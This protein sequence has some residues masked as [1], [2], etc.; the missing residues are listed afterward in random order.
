M[1]SSCVSSGYDGA[2]AGVG[3]RVLDALG[4][5][6]ANGPT[7]NVFLP[8]WRLAL[9][10]TYPLLSV[11]DSAQLCDPPSSDAANSWADHVVLMGNFY[12]GGCSYE[13][14][15]RVAQQR[16]AAGLLFQADLHNSFEWDGS[17]HTGLPPSAFVYS[18]VYDCLFSNATGSA[19][20]DILGVDA[21]PL[22][23]GWY[24]TLNIILA[25]IILP[26]ILSNV[27]LGLWQLHRFHIFSMDSSTKAVVGLE[28]VSQAIFFAKILNG[29][30][31]DHGWPIL[32]PH[33]AS[34]LTISV[35]QDIH[36]IAL[37]LVSKQLRRTVEQINKFR[38][39]SADE[40]GSHNPC[41]AFCNEHGNTLL[42]VVVGIFILIELAIAIL[43]ANFG[44][45]E[46]TVD[47]VRAA[48]PAR[49]NARARAHV[50]AL[51]IARAGSL[52]RLGSC[53]NCTRLQ[54]TRGC[55]F[56]VRG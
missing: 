49:Q 23:G 15:A 40:L 27:V 20:V 19:S 1:A 21:S 45:P 14:R 16:G 30:G 44:A 12:F 2:T 42:D 52:A 28:M 31:Y 17:D 22:E 51:G 35:Y 38:T 39:V 32:L 25:V 29:T 55:M 18:K 48:A 34:R 8:P 3:I 10:G 36:M 41:R 11:T 7:G 43:D 54:L 47:L 6:L 26:L 13:T 5:V 46:G 9:N 33:W 56:V 37:L 24:L 4:G 50:R 53:R